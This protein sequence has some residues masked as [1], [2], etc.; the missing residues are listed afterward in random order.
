MT[1]SP[2]HSTQV[3]PYGARRRNGIFRDAGSARVLAVPHCV[4]DWMRI[5]ANSPRTG[6]FELE[7]SGISATVPIEPRA[8]DD[9]AAR[10]LADDQ[11][12]CFECKI[13]PASD[14]RNGTRPYFGSRLAS[15][16]VDEMPEGVTHES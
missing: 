5:W 2:C 3:D 16:T 14:A 15:E 9:R 6:S 11:R 8:L 7:N 12:G 13:M 4:A 10:L 1:S